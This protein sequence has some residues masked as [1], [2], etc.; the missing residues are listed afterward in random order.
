MS[1]NP[2]VTS[3]EEELHRIGGIRPA[4]DVGKR[5]VIGVTDHVSAGPSNGGRARLT[6]QAA[7]EPV[8]RFLRSTGARLAAARPLP[9]GASAWA[10]LARRRRAAKTTKTTKHSF[11][12]SKDQHFINR[13]HA[14]LTDGG[15]AVHRKDRA[16]HV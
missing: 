14:F 16:H 10:R 2:Y 4:V 3:G 8:T 12:R 6:V 1:R 11:D 9:T 13:G 5:L 7:H 15:G